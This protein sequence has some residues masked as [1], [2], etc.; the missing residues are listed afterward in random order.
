MNGDGC[1]NRCQKEQ[2]S[3]NGGSSSGSSSGSSTPAAK[4]LTLVGNVNTNINNVFV[5]LKTDKAYTFTNENE[6]ENFIKTK[7]PDSTAVPSVYCSQ[8][9]APELDTFDCLA[10]YSS[11]IPNQKYRIEFSYNYQ[12]DSGFI[13][14]QVDPL[15]TSFATRNRQNRP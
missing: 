12:G 11:G 14:V 15:A 6:M 3:G 8:R 5:V 13:S 10:I 4:G 2:S 7:F 1:S 9:E